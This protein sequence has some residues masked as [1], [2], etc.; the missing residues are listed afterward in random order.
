MTPRLWAAIALAAL[1]V[2]LIAVAAVRV[3]WQPPPAPRSDQLAALHSLP[4]DAVRRGRAFQSALRP[5]MYGGLV[6]GLL[7]ALALGLTPLGARLV[8]LAG[9]PFGGHWLAEV[10]LGGL[11]VLFTGELVGLRVLEALE[12][13]GTAE[14]QRA[15]EE[16]THGTEERW[17]S[18]AKA[19]LE[20]LARRAAAR[21]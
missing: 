10:V 15:L 17:A 7:V 8:R 3:P 19:A 20:R 4:A 9:R 2:V 16:A 18:E 13:A 12:L 5:G 14:A 11:V 21:K 6:V 1:L